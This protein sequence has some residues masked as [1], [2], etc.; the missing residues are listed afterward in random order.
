MS[1]KGQGTKELT[2]EW[3]A[4]QPWLPGS[5]PSSQAPVTLSFEMQLNGDGFSLSLATH[6]NTPQYI[7]QATTLIL[8]FKAHLAPGRQGQLVWETPI[9]CSWL[10]HRMQRSLPFTLTPSLRGSSREK[11]ERNPASAPGRPAGTASHCGSSKHLMGANCPLIDYSQ[12]DLRPW[13]P[14]S[15]HTDKVQ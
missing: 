13:R 5:Q 12:W 4:P 14:P 3:A 9:L 7:Y 6:T 2:T 11:A 1:V 8:R 15:E 10:Q